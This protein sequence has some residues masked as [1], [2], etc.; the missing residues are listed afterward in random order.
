MKLL[1]PFLTPLFFFPPARAN[2]PYNEEKIAK[3]EKAWHGL[4]EKQFSDLTV[5]FHRLYQEKFPGKVLS[6]QAMWDRPEV[7]AYSTFDDDDNPQIVIYGGLARHSLMN[8]DSMALIICHELGH[9]L[10]GAPRKFRGH[11]NLLSW[12]S[13]EGQA[14]YYA[15]SKCLKSFFSYHK[16]LE[17]IAD[18]WLIPA[19]E[20]SSICSDF[21]CQRILT[22][23]LN[24][25]KIYALAN[26]QDPEQISL[27]K[28]DQSK[29]E[30][31][32]LTHPNP[33]CRLD[34][35]VAGLLCP[36]PYNQDFDEHDPSIGPCS[37]DYARPLCWYHP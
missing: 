30:V 25:S 36:I 29:V 5:Q 34:T 31:T 16:P 35:Y 28:K 1:I 15:T 20:V 27:Y 21:Y 10:G 32:V 6:I 33:Q 17:A 13:A 2:F 23:S 11:S 4:E 14:D 22:A 3:D 9:F 8:E 24:V 7:R 19:P 18:P 37:K 12:A 26:A